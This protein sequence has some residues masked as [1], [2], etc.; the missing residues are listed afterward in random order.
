MSSFA[1]PSYLQSLGLVHAPFP[2][3]PDQDGFFFSPRLTQQFAELCHFIELRKGF[4][5]V[6]GD[7]GVGKSTLARLLLAKLEADGVRTAL[8]FNTFLQGADLLRAIIRDFD[9]PV[10]EDDLEA[11]LQALN[12]WLLKQHKA[13]HN[14]VLILDDAQ[15]LDVASLELVRQLSNLETSDAK[16]L[17]IVMVA[18]PEI[19]DTLARH[20]LR[21][22]AS[23][24][25]LRLELRPLSLEE[26]DHYLHHRLVR[27][28]NA[29]ALSIDTGALK[30]LHQLSQGYIRRLHLLMD[31]CLFG[32][33]IRDNKRVTKTLMQ[34]A[35]RE[36]G[37]LKAP[38]T[39]KEH[40]RRL[41]ILI[42][43][44]CAAITAY[45]WQALLPA[46]AITKEVTKTEAEAVDA[47][48][49]ISR[50]V[51]PQWESFLAAYPGLNWPAALP[52]D[53][54][55]ISQNSQFGQGWLPVHLSTEL[56]VSCQNHPSYP[57]REGR[58]AFFQTQLPT[59]AVA[60]GTVSQSIILLQQ[61]L[62]ATGLLN[63]SHVDGQMG[64]LTAAALARFQQQ[65]QLLASG[66]PNLAS[67]YQLTCLH[68]GG[69]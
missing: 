34:Q 10:C 18:Q 33:A 3:T 51:N 67:A 31:R 57:L 52:V 59:S 35:A 17:Q 42:L 61:A 27:A 56:L 41:G 5:L 68:M 24:L 7:V 23:R 48:P 14:C 63:S 45:A 8:V 53:W 54:R 44:L 11:R 55:D 20:D 32:L 19:D 60:F 64:P 22:L 2:V 46:S 13:G 21:Q 43:L 25:A 50:P 47:S 16:L 4:M 58:L 69:E 62:A 49:V 9:I 26:T 12:S 66:Q 29:Q 65:Q 39:T 28:G 37:L 30:L 38:V 6:T 1:T 36:L 40:S 15:A